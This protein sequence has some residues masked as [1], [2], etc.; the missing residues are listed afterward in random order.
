MFFIVLLAIT[1]PFKLPLFVSTRFKV[2]FKS[3]DA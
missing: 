1:F 3:K 2:S